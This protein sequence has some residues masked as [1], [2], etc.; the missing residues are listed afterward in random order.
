MILAGQAAIPQWETE[1]C[2]PESNDMAQWVQRQHGKGAID[3]AG[4]L[5][6]PWWV[7]NAELQA[8]ELVEAFDI[9][10]N[11][12]TSH[13][14]PLNTFQ[15]N[16][17]NRARR[18]QPDA[19]VAQRLKRFSSMM[20]KLA[21]EPKMKLSQ[22]QDLGGCRA[23]MSSVGAVDQLFDL[24][25]GGHGGETLFESEG[26]LK[27]YDYLRH[28]K[29]DGYRGI[30]V[31]GRFFSRRPV[32]QP[33]DA[34]RIEVQLRSRLQ[35]AFATTVETVTTFTREPLKFGGGPDEWKRFFSLMGSAL[36]VRERTA[37]VAGTPQ[38]HT[39]LTR[40]LRDITKQLKVRPRLAGWARALR[41]LP[42]RNVKKFKWLLLILS[43]TVLAN[44]QMRPRPNV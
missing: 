4:E 12:R 24:Y 37:L 17:R 44:A 40:E 14:F 7:D 25:R 39:E 6:I 27:C 42:R 35:H 41:R 30:H 21:R 19:L 38:D 16:L 9:V 13:A 22:M 8:G 20:N 5:L 23:I 11:W 32:S 43:V 28:P 2:R 10:Q 15:V 1:P 26:T 33:W 36:A 29:S 34:Y 3:R 18:V 31:V